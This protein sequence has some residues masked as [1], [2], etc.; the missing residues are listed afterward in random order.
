MAL[1][2][3]AAEVGINPGAAFVIRKDVELPNA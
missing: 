1:S 2:S 3:D